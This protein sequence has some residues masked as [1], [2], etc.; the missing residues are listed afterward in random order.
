MKNWQFWLLIFFLS[1]LSYQ[2]DYIG[3]QT[4]EV[5]TQTRWMT[6]KMDQSGVERIRVDI[7]Q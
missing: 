7:G 4:K 2:L 3:K 6:W 5:F 1:G